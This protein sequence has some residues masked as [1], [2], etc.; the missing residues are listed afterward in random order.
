MARRGR[1]GGLELESEYWRLLPSWVG[2]SAACRIVGI[3][4]KTS[5]QWQAKNGSLPPARSAEEA[6][7][8]P[9]SVPFEATASA[10]PSGVDCLPCGVPPKGLLRVPSGQLLQAVQRER[11]FSPGAHRDDGGTAGHA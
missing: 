9:I 4:R 7:S 3:A 10:T 6:R 2:T 5:Y 8:G 11:R 1:K